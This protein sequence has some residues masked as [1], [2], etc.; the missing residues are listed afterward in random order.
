MR[1]NVTRVLIV[2]VAALGLIASAC[3]DDDEKSDD[4][5]TTSAASQ[6]G[7]RGNKDGEL[8]LG[9]LVPQTGDLS[10]IVKSLQTPVDMAVAS[11]NAAGGVNGKP[12][13]VVQADDGTNPN[14]AATSYAK[15]VNTDKVD[16]IIGPA[17]SNVAAKL[18][19]S[20]GTDKVPT[21]SGSTTA[22]NLSGGGDGYFFRTAPGDDLQGPALATLITGDGK[23]KVAIL[24]RNDDYGEGFSES[25]KTALEDGGAEVTET[26]LYN[27][28][29]SNF[30][31]DVQ[32]ALDS[33]P[34]A[35]AVIGF[36]D[37]GAKVISTM[38][39]KGAG[40]S[41]IPIYTADGM[42]S[43][44][45]AKTVDPSDPSKIAGIKG[46]APAAAP[47]GIESPFTAE[48]AATGIDTI[49]SSYYWDCT[50]L[51]ALAAV[52]AKS[53]DSTAIAENFA[54]NL[55]GDN[56]CNNFADCKKLLE[57]GKTIHYRGASSMF[58]KWN[59]MEPGTGVYDVWAYG[60]DGKSANVE[61]AAQIAIG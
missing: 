10:A 37:D 49:F 45:F 16:A 2:A 58:E 57:D 17:P 21:C 29:A 31:A 42:Q 32:K 53:D 52:K 3:G 24:A 20:I 56:D 48:F 28:E 40:P 19:E 4:A 44:S 25:L 60:T 47:Q 13:V 15:L 33:S 18:Q 27:P 35:V 41:Q 1:R 38:I 39:G 54:S 51:M 34:D 5:T 55:E 23:N 12:V 26:V 14:V 6:G 59:E 30:D 9:T 61:G 43:S 22:A 8:K 11:I 46:T 7:D 50:N 36:N